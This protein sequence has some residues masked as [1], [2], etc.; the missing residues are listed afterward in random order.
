M[1]VHAY[2]SYLW[3]RL[4]SHRLREYGLQPIVGDLAIK[5]DLNIDVDEGGLKMFYHCSVHL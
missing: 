3:N 1:Y 2:Q 4:V 5:A